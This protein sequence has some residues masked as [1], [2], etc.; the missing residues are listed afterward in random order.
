MIR[1]EPFSEWAKCVD[2]TGALVIYLK[3]DIDAFGR[4]AIR[5]IENCFD[6]SGEQGD[7]SRIP[8]WQ[9][10]GPL[11]IVREWRGALG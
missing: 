3:V 6:I 2:A 1:H 7:R 8:P 5:D 4:S 11:C 9:V 10:I